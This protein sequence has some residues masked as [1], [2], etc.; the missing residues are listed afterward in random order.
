MPRK[1]TN[2]AFIATSAQI[3]PGA[4]IGLDIVDPEIRTIV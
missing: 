4:Y 3:M 1:E 2:H